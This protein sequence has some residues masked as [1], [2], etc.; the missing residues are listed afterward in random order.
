ML[1]S[2]AVNYL[3]LG[4]RT[5]F[6]V[7]LGCVAVA[8][9]LLPEFLQYGKTLIPS[10]GPQIKSRLRLIYSTVPKA[11]F[12]HFYYLSTALSLVNVYLYYNSPVVWLVAFHSIRRLY[13]TKVICKYSSSSRMNWSHYVV[14]IWFYTVLNTI[15]SLKHYERKVVYSLKPFSF[16]LFSLASWDQHNNHRT[17]SKLVKYSLPTDGLFR[18][19]CCPH[20]FDEVLIYASLATYNLELC[21]PLLWAFVNLSVSALE[22]KKYYMLRFPRAQV[23]QYAIVPFIL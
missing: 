11:W 15:I 17:L 5:T 8:K 2:I 7:G 14:G 18:W 6:L 20:Y 10:N 9:F 21:W 19:V 4:C 3:V 16:L 22:N 12:A 13:E 23:P 1:D